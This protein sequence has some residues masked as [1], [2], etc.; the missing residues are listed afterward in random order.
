VNIKRHKPFLYIFLYLNHTNN[1][2]NMKKYFIILF[3]NII[4]FVGCSNLKNTPIGKVEELF[5]KYQKY[6]IEVSSKLDE[7]LSNTTLTVD[8][9]EKYK[10]IMKKQYENLVY[11]IKDDVING[12]KASVIAEI[13]V[14][15][16]YKIISDNDISDFDNILESMENAKEKVTYTVYFTLEKV[17]GVWKVSNLNQDNIDKISGIYKY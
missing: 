14:T 15:D 4:L 10:Q 8:Q 12:D 7:Y 9:K 11:K 13:I 5:S 3:I 2:D 17:N 6:D 1:G 16:Y